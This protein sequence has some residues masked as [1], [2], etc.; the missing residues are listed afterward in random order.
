M[1]HHRIVHV[2]FTSSRHLVVKLQRKE[3]RLTSARSGSCRRYGDR[4][5]E[6]WEGPDGGEGGGG[7]ASQFRPAAGLNS[8]WKCWKNPPSAP[9]AVPP[10]DR[11]PSWLAQL[12]L[13]QLNLAEF[14]LAWLA[15]KVKAEWKGWCDV[16]RLVSG[17]TDDGVMMLL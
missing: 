7:Q 9:T 5:E 17:Q 16:T 4:R 1:T 15:L 3:E 6:E 2:T 8:N 13:A 12:I 10:P 11:N 14:S